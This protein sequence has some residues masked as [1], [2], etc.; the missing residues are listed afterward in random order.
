LGQHPQRDIPGSVVIP[1]VSYTADTIEY[2]LFAKIM[3]FYPT[4]SAS[5]TC[6]RLITDNNPIVECSCL[7]SQALFELEMRQSH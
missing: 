7:E 2:F 5:F 1:I 3:V 6:V 4:S